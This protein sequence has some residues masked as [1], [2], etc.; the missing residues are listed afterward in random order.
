MADFRKRLGAV[1]PEKVK[2][3]GWARGAGSTSSE[4][5]RADI[6]G[7]VVFEERDGDDAT[8]RRAVLKELGEV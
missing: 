7:I 3:R 6:V 1:R 4:G 8:V 5:Q 2:W